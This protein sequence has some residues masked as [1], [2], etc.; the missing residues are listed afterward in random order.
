MKIAH[1]VDSMD[2]GGAETIVA[3]MCRLQRDQGHDPRIYAVAS[4]GALGE[5]ML[6]EGFSVKTHLG[7]SLPDGM[8]NF[9]RTFKEAHPDIVHIHNPTPTIYAAM[10]A[11]MTGV[12]SIISTRHSLVAEPRNRTVELKYAV[13]ARCCD[14]VVGICDATA[15][16]LKDIR[17]IPR[18]KIVRV[19]NGAAPLKRAAKEQQPQKDGFTLIFV[20][21]L[22]PVK[23]HSLLLRAFA[24][25][26]A[27]MSSLRLWMVGDGSERPRLE[28][29]ANELGISAWVTFWGQRLDVTPFLSAADV[30]IMSS[31]SEGLPMSLLQAFSLGLP[32]IVTDIGGMA[33]VVRLSKAGLTA[34]VTDP[35]E[36]AAAILRL[37]H[38]DAEREQLSK[39][40]EEAF[41]SRFTLQAMVDAYADLYRNTPR[42]HAPPPL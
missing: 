11:R 25:A 12:P 40:A 27:S 4:L 20:G 16:N 22:E 39:N 42:A 31:K 1:V 15:N 2:V 29:L 38:D 19:Y 21:R 17:S 37:A 3:Q 34:S 9:F 6:R 24:A 5:Q 7:R 41:R 10:P 26:H 14:W 33:E 32:A 23:N 28:N 13:A 35:A 30:F 36:M 8:R 18:R